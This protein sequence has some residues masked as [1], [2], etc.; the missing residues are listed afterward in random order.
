MKNYKKKSIEIP[1]DVQNLIE[2][3]IEARKNKDWKKSD[4][5]RDMI[6]IKGF[7]VKDTPNGVEVEK[8]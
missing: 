7:I 8:A 3:R 4:T 2:E 5:L 6:K 1:K